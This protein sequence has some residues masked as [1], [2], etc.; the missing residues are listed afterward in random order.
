MRTRSAG[1][2]FIGVGA[3]K[4][5]TSWIGYV[6]AQHPQI[7]CPRK[8]VNFFVRYFHR[9]YGWYQHWF[10]DRGGRKAGEISSNYLY[11]PRPDAAHKQFYPRWIPRE[12]LFFWRRRPSARDEI[13]ARYPDVKVFAIFRNPIERAW[14]HYWMWRNRKERI[15][16]AKRVVP[17]HQMFRD[18]GRWIRTQGYYGHYLAHWREHFPDMGVF[19]Y[20]D[21][22]RDPLGLARQLFG[23][24]EVDP[25]FVP[26]TDEPIFKGSY[27]PMADADRALV[28]EAYREDN[29]RFSELV[30]R[31]FSHWL[32]GS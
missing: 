17:F 2:D 24:L 21:L 19:F 11:S 23:F 14:S 26:E 3:Q 31:D 12:R 7:F 8:G 18:D 6:L 32:K 4:S 30:G 29:R 16:K 25:D 1:P 9:G 5:G 28:V 15:G 13:H 10:D 27:E 22:Q 20:D